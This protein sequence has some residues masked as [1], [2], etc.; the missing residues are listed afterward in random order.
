M[1]SID[2]LKDEK[3]W[4]ITFYVGGRRIRRSLRVESHGR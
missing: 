3:Y 2:T 4:K 1:S